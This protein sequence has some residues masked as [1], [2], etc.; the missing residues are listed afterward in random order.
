MKKG[1]SIL[2]SFIL[3]ASHM[4]LTVGTHFCGGEAVAFKVIF[5][6]THLGC[7]MP[8]MEESCNDFEK[9]S[10]KEVSLNKIP[11]CENEYQTIHLTNEYVKDAAQ[12]GFTVDFATVFIYSILNIELA[13]KPTHRFYTEHYSPPLEKDAQVLFQTF[14]I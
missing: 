11:C 9:S 1:F 10:K 13:S 14:L 4:Y 5:G 7:E 6:E 8:L 12:A 3:L 2:L